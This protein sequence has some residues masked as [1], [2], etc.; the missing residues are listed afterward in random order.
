MIHLIVNAD[1]FGFSRGVNYG[2]LDCHQNGIVNSATMMMNAAGTEHAIELAKENPSL[3]I[4][5][6]LVLTAG[7]PLSTNVPSLVDEEGN[8]KKQAHILQHK[9]VD[10]DELEREW[11]AQIEVFL[12]SGLK[13]THFD[14]HHHMHGIREFYPVVQKLSEKYQLPVR[15]CNE[16]LEGIP[17]FTDVFFHDFYGETI[18]GDYFEHLS[19]RVEDGK[20]VEVMCHPA[21]IDVELMSSSSYNIARLNETEILMNTKLPE[22][23]NLVQS[24]NKRLV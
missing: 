21:Y 13:P 15:K 24:L 8:F 23:I 2:I 16:E 5:I 17:S 18:A 1:D 7:K 4:G 6:H 11:S 3:Q 14:S 9:D 22:T 10:L 20:T 12:S 19:E